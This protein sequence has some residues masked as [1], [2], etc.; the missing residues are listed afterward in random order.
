[1]RHAEYR[2]AAMLALGALAAGAWGQ[3]LSPQI[4]ASAEARAKQLQALSTDPTVVAA[5]KAYNA[6][7]SAEAKAMTNEKWK[8]LSI[9]DPFVRSLSRNSLAAY[10]KTKKDDSMAECFVSGADGGKVAFLSKTSSWSHKGKDKHSVPMSGR[11]Y[12]G[13]LEVDESSGAQV[14]QI[15]LPVLDGGKPIG[16]IVVGLVAA[17][18]K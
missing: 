2:I 8:G 14:V 11:I 4:K 18:L 16:S 6:S 12:Y 17:R 13:P 1:M 5:V 9:L 3:T 10:L 7:P 15:G